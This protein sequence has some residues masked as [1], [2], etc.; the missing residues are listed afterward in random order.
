MPVEYREELRAL[1][2]QYGELKVKYDRLVRTQTWTKAQVLALRKRVQKMSDAE[3]DK[4]DEQWSKDNYGQQQHY[5]R[6]PLLPYH[7]GYVLVDSL[8]M[9]LNQFNDACNEAV[10]RSCPR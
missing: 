4:F 7:D 1:R 8:H 9:F 2:A 3:F 6:Y 5:G 10:H